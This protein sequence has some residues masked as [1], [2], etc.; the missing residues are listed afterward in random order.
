MIP[1][2]GVDKIVVEGVGRN[3]LRKGPGHYPDTPMPGQPGNAAIAGHRTTYGAPFNRI[4]ELEPGDEILVTTLQGPFT[5]EVT[6]TEIVTPVGGRGAS[7]TR[8]T[9]ASR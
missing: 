3:D 4:D 7:R 5:Y 9:I 2:I 6:G 8:A 1:K